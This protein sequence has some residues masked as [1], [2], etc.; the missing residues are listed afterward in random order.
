M[1]F[2]LLGQP[3]KTITSNG[4]VL[5]TNVLQQSFTTARSAI[6]EIAFGLLRDR[7]GIHGNFCSRNYEGVTIRS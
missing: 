3:A 1:A 4:A 7:R 6:T 5:M 2:K